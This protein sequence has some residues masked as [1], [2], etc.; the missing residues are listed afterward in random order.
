MIFRSEVDAA[1]H[2]ND[3]NIVEEVAD[4]LE[5]SASHTVPDFLII[6]GECNMSFRS[7]GDAPTH[8][9][10]HNQ[11]PEGVLNEEAITN[12]TVDVNIIN[13]PQEKVGN[14]YTICAFCTCITSQIKHLKNQNK[15]ASVHEAANRVEFYCCD[16]CNYRTE[17]PSDLREHKKQIHNGQQ[18]PVLKQTL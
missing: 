3:P 9:K 11:F 13:G 2:M 18:Q 1:T 14:L 8:M 7:E 5:T 17:Q 16:V 15:K 10:T 6:C 4:V 12:A